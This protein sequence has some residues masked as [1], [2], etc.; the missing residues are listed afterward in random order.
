LEPGG[1]GAKRVQADMELPGE[2][3]QRGFGDGLARMQQ[4]AGI[5]E[6]AELE[7]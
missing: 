6:R 4:A 7:G 3:A 5:A 1:I 2:E